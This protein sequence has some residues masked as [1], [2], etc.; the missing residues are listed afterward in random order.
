VDCVTHGELMARAARHLAIGE[1]QL[2]GQ[3]L[4]GRDD[5]L[6]AITAFKELLH[7]VAIHARRLTGPTSRRR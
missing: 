6:Q 5:A 7:A 4:A 3:P 2:T 1:A